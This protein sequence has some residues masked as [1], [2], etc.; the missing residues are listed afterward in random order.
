MLSHRMIPGSQLL[1]HTVTVRSYP[2]ATL[3]T[4]GITSALEGTVSI[5]TSFLRMIS[6]GQVSLFMDLLWLFAMWQVSEE[7]V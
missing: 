7:V 6:N 5:K 4:L 2:T 3:M 1:P